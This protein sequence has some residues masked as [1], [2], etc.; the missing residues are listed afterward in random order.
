MRIS[1]FLFL[2]FIMLILS[3]SVALPCQVIVAV[4]DTGLDSQNPV[5]RKSLWVNKGEIPGNNV[6]DDGNGYIDDTNGWDFTTNS[7]WPEDRHGHG[8]HVTGIIVSEIKKLRN[9]RDCE[10]LVMPLKYYDLRVSTTNTLNNTVSALKYAVTMGAHIINYSGG[11]PIPSEAE[12]RALEFANQKG[13]LL[14]AAAGN[15]GVNADKQ[16]FFPAGYG[17]PNIISVA[18]IDQKGHLL[19]SSNYGPQ[20]VDIAAP[21]KNII[22]YLA[23]GKMGS[24]TGTSQATA[25]VT[26]TSAL[27]IAKRFSLANQP[28]AII[29]SLEASALEQDDVKTR[30]GALD[31]RKSLGLFPSGI[32]AVGISARNQNSY[33]LNSNAIFIH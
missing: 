21:G 15:N 1:L 18:A 2:F 4:I 29:Q 17:L 10:V 22:S 5:I 16:K 24:M 23:Q 20:T 13:I 6:D 8:T 31:T 28:R 25:F 27:V 3:S 12:K 32:S 19:E 7:P 14:V 11:G 26:A 33:D 30:L 9:E